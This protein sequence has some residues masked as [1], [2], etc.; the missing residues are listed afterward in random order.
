MPI[1]DLVGSP[2]PTPEQKALLEEVL[3]RCG[4]PLPKR[5][6]W[7]GD[8]GLEPASLPGSPKP[9]PMGGGAEAVLPNGLFQ[10]R[11]KAW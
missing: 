2:H 10:G 8:D 4:L 6:P 3:T 1:K 7:G 11:R 5:P 9:N